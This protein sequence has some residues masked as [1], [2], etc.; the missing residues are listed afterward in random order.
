MWA[1]R[2]PACLVGERLAAATAPV[3]W[4]K[5]APEFRARAS[6]PKS[7]LAACLVGRMASVLR[8]RSSQASGGTE[9]REQSDVRAR[10][11][12]GAR[13]TAAQP[14][15]RRSAASAAR[16]AARTPRSAKLRKIVQLAVRSP[17]PR[18]LRSGHDA[19]CWCCVL[20]LPAAVR[21]SKFK[22]VKAPQSASRR[23]GGRQHA[24]SSSGSAAA[25]PRSPEGQAAGLR[26]DSRTLCAVQPAQRP[27]PA[28][29]RRSAPAS[30]RSSDST[31]P[32][33][34]CEEGRGLQRFSRCNAQISLAVARLEA[35]QGR[36]LRGPRWMLFGSTL[37][38][39][40]A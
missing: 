28:Q 40:P 5:A 12:E 8:R 19:A 37:V 10:R 11:E 6:T 21:C 22:D 26:A 4:Q 13:G 16:R 31:S 15:R 20:A 36:V 38:A 17:R 39:Q 29:A 32:S 1:D 35:A 3:P 9:A 30:R 33:G 34:P 25:R 23:P 27:L 24:A 14:P 2:V 7:K 18:S